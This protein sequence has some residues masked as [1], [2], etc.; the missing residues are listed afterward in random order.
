M[1]FSS[2]TNFGRQVFNSDIRWIDGVFCGMN[3]TYILLVHEI[4]NYMLQMKIVVKRGEWIK[5]NFT[6]GYP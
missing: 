5:I 4:L 6:T 1:L 2:L 3:P